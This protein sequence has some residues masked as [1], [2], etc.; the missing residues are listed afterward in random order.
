MNEPSGR[1]FVIASQALSRAP[2][3]SSFTAAAN[4]DL[5]VVPPRNGSQKSANELN[6]IASSTVL[7]LT[8]VRPEPTQSLA[9][10]SK[11]GW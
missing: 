7:L 6:S 1:G 9:N 3:L 11:S 10:S 8:S 5:G 4:S 2:P